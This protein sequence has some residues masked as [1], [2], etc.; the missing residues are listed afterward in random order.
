MSYS[1]ICEP[2]MSVQ[3]FRQ[4]KNV[5]RFRWYLEWS[6]TPAYKCNGIRHDQHQAAIT[7]VHMGWL[8]SQ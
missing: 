4:F 5:L 3:T 8:H 6:N 1:C 7:C 2:V